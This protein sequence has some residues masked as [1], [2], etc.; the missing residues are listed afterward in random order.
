MKTYISKQIKVSVESF[1]KPHS[2]HPDTSLFV[3]AYK[4]TIENY[5]DNTVKLV[6]RHWNIFDSAI[7][8]KEIEGDG[9]IGQQPV[10][11]PG[12]K[13][14]YVSGCHLKS[15][16]GKMSGNYIFEKII[17]GTKFQVNIPE[18]YLIAPYRMN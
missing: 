14:Q 17:D 4:I 1:Y 2:S 18:F 5:S 16:L 11:E 8:R 6:K 15:E 9:V 10:L 13:Y 12:E 3:F 7:E